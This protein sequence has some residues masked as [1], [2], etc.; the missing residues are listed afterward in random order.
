[1]YGCQDPYAVNLFASHTFFYGHLVSIDI[2]EF[3]YRTSN[4]SIGIEEYGIEP[5]YFCHTVSDCNCV[6]SDISSVQRKYRVSS[7]EQ[8]SGM[9]T[10]KNIIYN[11]PLFFKNKVHRGIDF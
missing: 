4:I 9:N 10:N 2:E 3:W 6:L 5:D 8:N 7:I 1:M 11:M